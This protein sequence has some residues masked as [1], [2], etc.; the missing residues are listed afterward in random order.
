MKPL[1]VS[2][3]G[4][5]NV[6]KTE[7]VNYLAQEGFTTISPLAILLTYARERDIKIEGRH[8]T[9]ELRARLTEEEGI[10]WVPQRILASRATHLVLEGLST[11]NDYNAIKEYA[12]QD[13]LASVMVALTCSTEG[14]FRRSRLRGHPTKDTATNIVEYLGATTPEAYNPDPAKMSRQEIVD[15]IPADHRIDTTNLPLDEVCQKVFALVQPSL[16]ATA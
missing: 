16:V 14:S 7:V 11:V 2:I 12:A 9:A 1:L 6:G 8:T 4:Q 13:K 3:A 10:N 5:P 15:L